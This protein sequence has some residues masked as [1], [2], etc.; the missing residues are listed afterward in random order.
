MKIRELQIE[1]AENFLMLINTTDAETPFLLYE[2]GE[3]KTTVEQER[4]IIQKGKE[5]G[6]ITYVV[7]H[8]KKL[9]GFIWGGTF[10]ENRRKH[11]M[12][13]AIA[14]LQEYTGKGLGTKLLKKLVEKGKQKGIKRFDLD[15]SVNNTIAINLYKKVGFEIEGEKKSAYLI[16]GKF[17]ND[18]I[19][20]KIV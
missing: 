7:E 11:C 12:H 14:V 6:T 13:I 9:V 1:D 16:D 10:T 19:M 15:V 20:A 5:R 8:E 18:Y 3:R 17:D 4:K 2:A